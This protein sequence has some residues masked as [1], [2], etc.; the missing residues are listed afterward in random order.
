MTDILLKEGWTLNPDSKI[1]NAIMKRL[2]VTG[3][4]CPC[5]N[6]GKTKEDRMCPC[7]EYRE[8]DTCHCSLYVKVSTV[9]ENGNF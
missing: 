7:K 1:V 5:H 9:F 4:E 2:E 6:P 8:S 3:G